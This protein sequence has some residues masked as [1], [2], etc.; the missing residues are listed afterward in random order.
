[1]FQLSASTFHHPVQPHTTSLLV[2][3]LCLTQVRRASS[4]KL[5]RLPIA[6]SKSYCWW[7]KPC[8]TSDILHY[9]EFQEFFVRRHVGFR[10]SAVCIYFMPRSGLNSCTWSPRESLQGSFGALPQSTLARHGRQLG[11]VV[12]VGRIQARGPRYPVYGF[13]MG[14]DTSGLWYLLHIWVLG[15]LGTEF[16]GR[17]ALVVRSHKQYS[18]LHTSH[19]QN[20]GDQSVSAYKKY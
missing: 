3:V 10:A 7:Y 18:V 4:T 2:C 5:G 11:A 19:S 16:V 9:R 14:N 8:M 20:Y 1:M 6:Q 12:E 17:E 13:C 15:P